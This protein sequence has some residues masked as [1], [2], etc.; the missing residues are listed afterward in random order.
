MDASYLISS[1]LI[2]ELCLLRWLDTALLKARGDRRRHSVSARKHAP[3][4][5]AFMAKR[6]SSC[7]RRSSANRTEVG[8]RET[9][10]VAL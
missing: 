3:Q 5:F 4:E 7:L 10:V 1:G 6:W 9:I 8:T 2:F